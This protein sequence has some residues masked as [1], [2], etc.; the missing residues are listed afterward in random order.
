MKV[1]MKDVAKKAGVST[2]T[3]SRVI[4]GNEKISDD[5]KEVV[6]KVMDELDYHPNIAARNLANNKTSTLGLILPSAT[7]DFMHNPFFIKVIAGISKSAKENG[8]YIMYSNAEDE[9]DE[10]KL[11]NHFIRSGAVDGVILTTVRTDDQSI[12]LLRKLNFPYV[13]IGRQRNYEKAFWVDNNNFQ[14]MYNVVEHLI[15]KNKSEIGFIGGKH[16]LNV[17]V[18]RLE[19][20]KKALETRGLKLEPQM[21]REVEFTELAGYQAIKGIL[22]VTSPDAIV[23]TDDMLA[24]GVMNYLQEQGIDNIAVAGFNNTPL[25][26][27]R[28]PSLTS[29]DISAEKLGYYAADLL[30]KRLDDKDL[31]ITNYIVDTKLIERESTNI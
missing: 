21:I 22:E 3:V 9:A 14:A 13:T 15:R 12:E 31:K 25:A 24:F 29:V 7:K 17:T 4:S 28:K 1:T 16:G 23:T 2:S 10:I 18:D 26:E 5:T 11:L 6:Y 19:G 30:I 8:Y 27:Y 20:Y